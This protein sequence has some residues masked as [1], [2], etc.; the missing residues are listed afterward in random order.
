MDNNVSKRH[1][2]EVYSSDE[3]EIEDINELQ[4]EFE[5]EREENCPMFDLEVEDLFEDW[6]SAERQVESY[7]KETGFEVKK[8]RLEKIKKVRSYDVPLS[9][10][11]QESTVHKREPTWKT[12]VN[13][14]V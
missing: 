3:E 9:A 5:S 11:F 10:S 1:L 4:E 6:D 8:S 14:R 2:F 7:A 12:P 13:E